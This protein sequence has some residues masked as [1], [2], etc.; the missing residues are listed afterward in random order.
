MD[1]IGKSTPATW[2]E[3]LKGISNNSSAKISMCNHS[4][5]SSLSSAQTGDDFSQCI[6]SNKRK[7][8]CLPEIYPS[9]VRLTSAG[10]SQLHLDSQ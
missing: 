5:E 2:D 10:N 9:K 8:K 3:F 6:L 7:D 1:T 4:N